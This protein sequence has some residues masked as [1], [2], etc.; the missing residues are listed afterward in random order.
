MAAHGALRRGEV[1]TYR[2]ERHTISVELITV[3]LRGERGE[4]T[5]YLGIHGDV[6]ERKR[7]EEALRRRA[8]QQ[9]LVSPASGRRAL[10][11]DDLQWVLEEAMT[12][13]CGRWASS[14]AL[15]AGGSCRR[16]AMR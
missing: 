9:A 14:W 16:I 5:G 12:C 11:S 10:A 6:S 2:K 15:L 7:G 13:W 1:V 8:E 4:T 3:A